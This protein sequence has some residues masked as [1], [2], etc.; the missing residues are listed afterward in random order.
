M[1]YPN[2]FI[3]LGLFVMGL[4]ACFAVP[5]EQHPALFFIALILTVLFALL[6]IQ[7]VFARIADRKKWEDAYEEARQHRINNDHIPGNDTW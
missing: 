7:S 5:V 4:C 2:P 3:F 1:L 6:A